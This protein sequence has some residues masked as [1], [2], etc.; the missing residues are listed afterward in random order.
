LG[1][2]SQDQHPGKPSRFIVS[3]IKTVFTIISEESIIPPEYLAGFSLKARFNSHRQEVIGNRFIKRRGKPTRPRWLAW[4]KR[5]RASRLLQEKRCYETLKKI[6][7]PC[8][9]NIRVLEERNFLGLI[10]YSEISM[11]LI[12]HGVD[13]RFIST[14][15]C[16]AGLRHNTAWRRKVIRGIAGW[17]RHMHDHD[18]FDSKLHF[19]NI[20]V[21]PDPDAADAEIYFIDVTGGPKKNFRRKNYLRMKDVAY[22]YHDACRWCTPRERILFM[23][24]FLGTRKLSF[25]DRQ[26]IDRIIQYSERRVKIKQSSS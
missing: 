7:V 9:D 25:A 26:F 17:I 19:G 11:D 20:L 1:N 13:L 8:P 23:H 18:Y 5:F 10:N 12:A 6:G 16:F 2:A 4:I 21:V 22:L 15:D 24:E 3:K 14:L